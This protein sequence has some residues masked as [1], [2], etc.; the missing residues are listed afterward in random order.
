MSGDDK[1]TYPGSGGVL[2]NRLGIRDPVRLDEALND[3]ASQRWAAIRG[4]AVPEVLDF[5]YLRSIHRRLF[6]PLLGWAGEVRD[7][8]AQAGDTGIAYCRPRFIEDSVRALFDGLAGEDYLRGLGRE[9]FAGRLAVRW[10]ELSAIHPFRDGNTR[11][12][13]VYVS[14]LAARAGYGIDWTRLDVARLRGLRIT[15]IAGTE[16]PLAS[17]L[18]EHLLSTSSPG[19]ADTITSP[20]AARDR[21]VEAFLLDIPAPKAGSHDA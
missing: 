2:V 9:E 17:Y 21:P 20:A 3:Y 7:V 4:E 8:D 11:S 5:G 1:Y 19:D 6:E 12:Q 10:G 16:G 13:S 14:V 18:G 15:A